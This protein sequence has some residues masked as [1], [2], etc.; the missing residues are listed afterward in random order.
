MHHTTKRYL[1]YI[2]VLSSIIWLLRKICLNKLG[3]YDFMI[4][5]NILFLL[6]LLPI[7]YYFKGN[8]NINSKNLDFKTI[9]MMIIIVFL[10]I[11]STIY[12][13]SII[14]NEEITTSPSLI[15]GLRIIGVFILGIISIK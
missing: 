11:I 9:S 6:F 15:Y 8:I 3:V 14:R 2:T 4:I 7:I 5:F 10:A 1:I 12:H 13:H